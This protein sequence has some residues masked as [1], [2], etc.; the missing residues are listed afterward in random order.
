MGVAE[1][2]IKVR[3]LSAGDIRKELPPCL[4][5]TRVKGLGILFPPYVASRVR[6]RLAR[7]VIVGLERIFSLV[8]VLSRTGD[9]IM[10]TAIRNP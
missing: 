8:P 10:M 2:S 6:S 4:R 5:V 3:Y 7:M 1:N 9:Q